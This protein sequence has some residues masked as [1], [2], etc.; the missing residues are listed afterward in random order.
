MTG[1]PVRKPKAPHPRNLLYLTNARTMSHEQNIDHGS[2]CAVEHVNHALAME[3]TDYLDI[4]AGSIA[5]IVGCGGKTSFLELMTKKLRDKKTLVSP[6]TKMFPLKADGVILCETLRQ[7]CAHAP[8]TG[9]QCLGLRNAA[10]GKLEALP[11]RVLERLIQRYD[12]A[13]LEADGSRGL[14]AKGWL[15]NEP[16]VPRYCTHTVGVITLGALGRAAEGTAV[17]R[18]PQFLT[19]TGLMEGGTITPQ[20]LEAMV[21]AKNGMFKNS[22]G[23]RFLLVNQVEDDVT[24]RAALVFLR[25][26]K[27]QYPD[28][29]EKLIYGSI[30]LDAW[31]EA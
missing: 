18:L 12:V 17:H 13:L 5:A 2:F 4:S 22:A 23:R 8:Q 28:Y 24:A 26:I 20:A 14:P 9:I 6:T 31:Q 21:C 27:K 15:T 7:C 29:F 11:G 30:H 10:T 16:V 19:L 1:I 25:M 3:I